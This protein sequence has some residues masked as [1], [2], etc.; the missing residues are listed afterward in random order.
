MGKRSVVRSLATL[1]CSGRRADYFRGEF[2]AALKILD[3]GDVNPEHFQG[4]WAGAFGNTQFMPSTFLRTAVSMDG[5]GH[6]DIVDSIPNALGSTARYLAQ[7]GWRSGLP[8]GFEVKVPAG[9]AGPVGRRDKHPMSFWSGRGVTR[10]D[11]GD[12][13]EGEAGL[14]LPSGRVGPAFLVTRNFDAI[15]AYNA[16]ETYALAIGHLADRIKGGADF[17]TPWP[18]DDP[19]LSRAERR[20]L[21]ALLMKRGFDVEKADGVIGSKTQ[22]AIGDYQARIGLSRDGRAGR[23]VLLALRAGK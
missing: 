5:T 14:L 22:A 11:G 18:T 9:Y 7:S 2:V 8:W 23:A 19:G 12:L 3:R 4:S 13:G 1:A 16:A 21:Q 15:Y 17:V 20:E 6:R 10:A